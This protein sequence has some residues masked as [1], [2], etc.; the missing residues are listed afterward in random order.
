MMFKDPILF[1]GAHPD[2]IDINAGATV[3]R[4]RKEGHKIIVAVMTH[5]HDPIR[6]NECIEAFVKLGISPASVYHY[7]FNDM[8]LHHE[9]TEMIKALDELIKTHEIKTV[10]THFHAD[11]HQ[12]HAAV[13]TASIAAARNVDNIIFYKP[14]YPSGRTDIPFNPNLVVNVSDTDVKQKLDALNEHQS[15]IVKYGDDSYLHA[16]EA[17]CKSDSW[18][19]GGHLGYAE[20]FQISRSKI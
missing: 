17:I 19:Y 20:V 7:N 11:T 15:Q 4:L 1:I 16:I 18:V 10:F 12:D 13:A 3:S 2:D 14:T 9:L 6:S 8:F 5:K